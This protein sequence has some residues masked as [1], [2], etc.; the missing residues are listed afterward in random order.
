MSDTLLGV[1]AVAE[2]L[3]KVIDVVHQRYGK[4]E[5][6]VAPLEF[7]ATVTAPYLVTWEVV[8]Q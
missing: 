8:R 6:I 4:T 3:D 7:A 1:V 5:P 2:L